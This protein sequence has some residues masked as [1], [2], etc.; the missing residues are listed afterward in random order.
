MNKEKRHSV[1][2]FTI[3]E[4][5]V[6]LAI[7]SL[8][9]SLMASSLNRFNEQLKVSTDVHAELNHWY[10]VRASIWQDF[11]QADSILMEA[12]AMYLYR[13][14]GVASY[15]V[16]EGTLERSSG[17][18]WMSMDISAESVYM[19]EKQGA[20]I[21]HVV[22]EWKDRPMDLRYHFQPAIDLGINN[23]FNTLHE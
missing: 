7:M 22:I 6:V 15:R 10:A 5:T 13:D 3:F 1:P 12:G 2:A 8:L 11:Y 23:Y 4:V 16:S 17:A 21:C 19:E 9:I 14:E 18:D 20:S